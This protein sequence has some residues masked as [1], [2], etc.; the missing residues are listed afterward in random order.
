[1]SARVLLAVQGPGEA[2]LVRAIEDS[3]QL[4]V[5]RRCADLPELLAAAAAGHGDIA[6]LDLEQEGV[7]AATLS[8]LKKHQVRVV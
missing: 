4:V 6:L 7:D 2:A 3:A 1:M 5:A 8:D